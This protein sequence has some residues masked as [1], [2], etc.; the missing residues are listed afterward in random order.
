MR[1]TIGTAIASV[2]F[3][4]LTAC[5][6]T[7]NEP[8][9]IETVSVTTTTTIPETTTTATP[10]TFERWDAVNACMDKILEQKS[11][12]VSPTFDLDGGIVEQ[13][14]GWFMQGRVVWASGETPSDFECLAKPGNP[15]T[16]FPVVMDLRNIEKFGELLRE[17]Q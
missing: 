17:S 11:E 7:T 16:A 6:T 14:G 13:N 9:P 2:A 4:A 3:V 15:P 1:K 5:S 8:F 12:I 10:A